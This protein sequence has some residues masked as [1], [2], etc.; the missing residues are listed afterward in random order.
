MPKTHMTQL[1]FPIIVYSYISTIGY[2][3]SAGSNI[4]GVCLQILWK[5][6][7]VLDVK[8]QYNLIITL[9][10]VIEICKALQIL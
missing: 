6:F 1:M 9:F 5:D 8:I 4:K 3:S 10:E 2:P 7:L